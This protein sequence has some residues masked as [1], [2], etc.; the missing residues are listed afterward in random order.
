M[1]FDR[2]EN[3]RLNGQVT[4]PPS[5]K[6]ARTDCMRRLCGYGILVVVSLIPITV[7]PF[8]G[9]PVIDTRR[10]SHCLERENNLWRFPRQRTLGKKLHVMA[11][12]ST[13]YGTRNDSGFTRSS[14]RRKRPQQR[15]SRQP[16][17][18][19]HATT[20]TDRQPSTRTPRQAGQQQPQQSKSQK[21]ETLSIEQLIDL[22]QQR[23]IRFS[24]LSTR[25]DLEGLLQRNIGEGETED[26]VQKEDSSDSLLVSD[27]NAEKTNFG[28][29][30]RSGRTKNVNKINNRKEDKPDPFT[31]STSTRDDSEIFRQSRERNGAKGQP[32]EAPQLRRTRR[33]QR[34][35]S[36]QS[37]GRPNRRKQNGGDQRFDEL[38]R[39]SEASSATRI[40]GRAAN[41]GQKAVKRASNRAAEWSHNVADFI[42]T[43]LLDD[44]EEDYEDD[45]ADERRINP[46]YGP[47]V[48]KRTTSRTGEMGSDIGHASPPSSD[49][50]RPR[51]RNRTGFDDI[52]EDR[53]IAVPGFSPPPPTTSSRIDE[54]PAAKLNV[55]TGPA[56]SQGDQGRR[57]PVGKTDKDHKSKDRLEQ[58]RSLFNQGK[59][60]F[61]ED[62]ANIIQDAV[63]ED[64]SQDPSL[65]I[66]T[67]RKKSKVFNGT[68]DVVSV[69]GRQERIGFSRRERKE[70]SSKPK[71]QGNDKVKKSRTSRPRPPAKSE[72]EKFYDVA[73]SQS[74]RLPVGK[75][76]HDAQDGYTNDETYWSSQRRERHRRQRKMHQ[77]QVNDESDKHGGS[78][79][80]RRTKKR[81]Y[82]SYPDETESEEYIMDAFDRFGEIV[83]DA[84]DTFLWGPTA[85]DETVEEDEGERRSY[86][87]N[88]TRRGGSG[89]PRN[90]NTEPG[91]RTSSSAN[92]KRPKY[93]PRSSQGSRKRHWRDRMEEQLDNLLG[94]HDDEISY[95]RWTEKER[96]DFNEAGGHDAISYAQGRSPKRRRSRK[97]NHKDASTVRFEHP[98]WH[99]ETRDDS[100]DLVSLL[101]GSGSSPSRRNLIGKKGSLLRF[102]QVMFWF[103]RK[104]FGNLVRWASVRGALPEPIVATTLFSIGLSVRPKRR[105]MALLIT[106][107]VMRLMGE[108]VDGGGP[109]LDDNAEEDELAESA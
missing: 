28:S 29:H 83:G 16:E 19:N 38:L 60:E 103:S 55:E 106:V 31:S 68:I 30:N 77:S 26:R 37:S 20:V 62:D 98:F 1:K 96:Q 58:V 102:F 10:I 45:A 8:S 76:G 22:L 70:V 94:L 2:E 61:K 71:H 101:F 41:L 49:K 99:F 54:V 109:Y 24:P 67:W 40:L 64:F 23:G 17:R 75:V 35:R 46:R 9:A 52:Q 105:F 89:Q 66:P 43:E 39:E 84:T 108:V 56:E 7:E 69:A 14:Q 32:D 4:L 100:T 85:L 34:S 81:I 88:A 5:R 80:E 27:E 72:G 74:K 93:D 13:L 78:G 18:S 50:R 51:R 12:S 65:R 97:G 82:S 53:V 104:L 87:P 63:I 95:K 107:I 90:S 48:K 21:E 44:D 15:L 79:P 92:R 73:Q 11:S 57:K 86:P 42:T 25:Q 3:G 6:R 36:R 59:K 47:R 91:R 33:Q